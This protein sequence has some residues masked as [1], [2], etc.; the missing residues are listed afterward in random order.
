MGNK[1]G[2][3]DV[4]KLR[5]ATDAFGRCLWEF[6]SWLWHGGPST[7]VDQAPQSVL[8]VGA[9]QRATAKVT[10]G[11]ESLHDTGWR[12]PIS[13]GEEVLGLGNATRHANGLP[14]EER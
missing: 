13:H 5:N 6:S 10:Y 14:L 8:Q 3:S 2:D 12:G 4:P 9:Y 1:N 11:E 7:H